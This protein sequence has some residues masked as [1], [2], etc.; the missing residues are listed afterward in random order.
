MTVDSS[1]SPELLVEA[2]SF[3]L[4]E[5]LREDPGTPCPALDET[6][7]ADVC[8][9]GGGFAGL[10]T[11]YELH[12]RE[13]SLDVV[14]LEAD[15]CGAGGSGANGGF[16]SSSWHD[17]EALCR[18]F[19]EHE[20]IR[21]AS[22]LAAQL[23]EVAA[24][25]RR[26]DAAI[27]LHNEGTVFLRAGEWEPEPAD[28][29]RRLLERH[30]LAG[31]LRIMGADE[32]RRVVDSP[33]FCGG[34]AIEDVG[35]VQPARLARELRRVLLERG[36]RI[37]EGT[38][39]TSLATG[40]PV[41]VRTPGGAVRCRSAVVATGAWAAA[42]PPFRRAFYVAVDSMVIT[43]PV[44]DL[45]DEMG[46]RHNIGFADDREAFYYVR[47]TD[48]GRVAIGGGHI[49]VAYDGR[50]EGLAF[51]DPEGAG[52][53]AGGLRWLFPALRDVRIDHAWTG[54]LDMTASLTPFF[55]S[56]P[57]GT[58]HVGLGFSGH[59]LTATRVGGKTLA[60]MVLG[61]D[62]EWSSLPV[63]GP[64]TSALPPEPLRRPLLSLLSGAVVRSE[65]AQQAGG[66]STVAGRLATRI[67]ETHRRLQRPAGRRRP[68]PASGSAG[69]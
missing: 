33:T 38:P 39:M 45:L 18:M 6:L 53:A 47:R 62:D 16:L 54:P 41:V 7:R 56:S 57:D 10:W 43:E 14:L 8:V 28:A 63:V 60:S 1:S 42:A 15:V 12:E 21:Y 25:C 17:I 35:T 69:G 22:A 5:A 36:I 52:I 2:R 29:P 34:T 20:G 44:P 4:Q 19:G 24:W 13:P 61:L 46:W 11:A 40:T 27:E 32:A 64:P 65:Q 58:V 48:A 67:F 37:C 55:M 23:D 31:K 68:S 49:G 50:I 59:G 3:W 26:H 9:I 30:G 51:T 66:R